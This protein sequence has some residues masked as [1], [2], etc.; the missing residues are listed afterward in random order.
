MTE[1]HRIP[2]RLIKE[3]SPYLLQHAYNPVDWHPWGN[4]AFIL[5]KETNRPILV[6]IGYAACHWCHV[7]EKE[8]FEDEAVAVVMNRDFVC[9]KID[10]EEYPAVDD[11]YMEAVQAIA[12]HG[13]WPLNCFLTPD[14]RPFYGGT[15]F[16]PVDLSGRPGWL[17]VLKY[18][19]NLFQNEREKVEEQA[20]RLTRHIGSEP[21]FLKLTPET[22]SDVGAKATIQ[23][24][25]KFDAMR[26][27]FEG[28][29][30]FPA[31]MVLRFLLSGQPANTNNPQVREMIHTSLN[32]M[33]AGGFYDQIGGGFHRY[34]V[35]AA[36]KIPHFEKMLYDNALLL[37]LYAEAWSKYK[38]PAWKQVVY[39]TAEF[40]LREMTDPESGA[41]YSALDADSEG[42]EGKFYT[43]TKSEIVDALGKDALGF[44]QK[45]GI[46]DVGNWE[47][48]NIPYRTGVFEDF[49]A[50]G[51][52]IIF[53]RLLALR[54]SKERPLTDTKI[55]TS[56]NGLMLQAWVQ[57]WKYFGEEEWKA[58]G[59]RL[60]E[61]I[62]KDRVKPQ[63][64]MH[65]STGIAATLE[66]YAFLIRGLIEAAWAWDRPEWLDLSIQLQAE[67]DLLM[68]DPADGFYYTA[69]AHA[70][71]LIVR[72][73]NFY[74][75][76]LPSGNAVMAENLWL[77]SRLTDRR[78][79]YFRSEKMIRQIG[80][81]AVAYPRAFGHWLM[82]DQL[83]QGAW[84]EVV[85][86]EAL[87]VHKDLSL[88]WKPTL[89]QWIP[90]LL[91]F[92][93]A[94]KHPYPQLKGKEIGSETAQWYFCANQHCS[95]PMSSPE[96][97]ILALIESYSK[98]DGIN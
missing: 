21:A 18:I 78:D 8:S 52:K 70:T 57:I 59:L 97:A 33:A 35:D 38:L 22:S 32:Q 17:T 63:G 31:S 44:C 15:Y 54:A 23:L 39:Q 41:C 67:A 14:A 5:A 77:L 98:P 81:V 60:A 48:V 65:T 29:P 80:S 62:V 85:G 36:W 88:V 45:F 93:S 20:D 71:G 47:G 27:G 56:W 94:S 4:E 51:E 74:D 89:S 30:K 92:H 73:K 19:S 25:Q 6:S 53:E 58:A 28:A 10:R 24:H 1:D 46:T 95:L 12:G 83:L 16:P 37:I 7:M 69:P 84:P 26:G 68:L 2:N 40:I 34:T 11:I 3:S 64:L 66:D 75:N 87:P 13:G 90:G 82:L 72:K 91:Y 55:L 43:W 96:E 61:W 79:L 76:A 9:I 86:V 50:A 49:D 42:V